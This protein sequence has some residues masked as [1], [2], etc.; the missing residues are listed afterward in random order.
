AHAD[1]RNRAWLEALGA[2]LGDLGLA[3]EFRHKSWA[4]PGLPAWL[5]EH[6]LEPVS[7]DVPDLPALFPP[8]LVVA[9]PPAYVGLPSRDAARWYASDKERYDFDYGDAEL[10]EWVAALRAA[11]A[12][13][14]GRGLV[15]FNNC[16]RGQA[17]ANARR[18]RALLARDAGGLSVV[19]PPAAGPV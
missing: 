11:A 5:A 7:V 3:V 12:G 1:R 6:R 16:W 2:E 4:G 14:A 13:G 8:G 15:L 10:G 17:V 18:L 9:G 19:E